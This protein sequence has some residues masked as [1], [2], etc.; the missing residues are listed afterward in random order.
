MYLE[1]VA[2]A[3][4]GQLY[5]ENVFFSG[6]TTD[7][8]KDCRE[9]LFIAL[10]GLHFDGHGFIPQAFVA[11]AVAAMVD[12][13][14]YAAHNT[15]PTVVVE[16]TLCGLGALAHWW[17][18]QFTVPVIAIT[19]SVGK[20]TVK[21]LAASIFAQRTAGLVT[22]GNLNNEIGVPLTLLRLEHGDGYAI[23]EMGMNHA[24]ELYR[25]SHMAQPDIALINNVAVAHLEG[26]GSLD[27]VA[28]AK[29][30]IFAGLATDGVA[31]INA[32]DHYAEYWRTLSSP[33]RIITFAVD[34]PADVS[35][36][37]QCRDDYS[38]LEINISGARLD[39]RLPAPGKHMVKN[40]LAAVSIALAAEVSADCIQQGLENF[41]AVKGRQQFLTLGTT[42]IVDDSYNANPA[43]MQAAMEVLASRGGRRIL[44]IGDMAELGAM[45]DEAHRQLGQWAT[46]YGFAQFLA[47]GAYAQQMVEKFKGIKQ[48]FKHKR[49]LLDYVSSLD[50]SHTTVLVKGSRSSHMEN[51][52][53]QLICLA[54]EREN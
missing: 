28:A 12:S 20:T 3:T 24:G 6:V 27:A 8:R 37:Y 10:K 19:G 21:E 45:S 13:S 7:S 35:A 15:Y 29:G 47:C 30:E 2:H 39:V 38:D 42:T 18:S 50:L 48:A 43:S 26:L 33:R 23:I 46:H 32:D 51:V 22:Q 31:I 17:R 49:A 53:E 34:H 36:R 40:A 25:L 5:G 52:V 16:D 41:T 14:E 54:K 4:N 1:Q 9:R 44:I 11:G